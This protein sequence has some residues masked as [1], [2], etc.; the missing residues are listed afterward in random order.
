LT[1]IQCWIFFSIRGCLSESWTSHLLIC[2]IQSSWC[3]VPSQI[4]C[5]EGLEY[6]RVYLT[7][8]LFHH[9]WVFFFSKFVMLPQWGSSTRGISQIWLQV[10]EES[11]KT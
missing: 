1:T 11:R 6:L 7:T 4:C 3:I 2:E 9:A 10:R 8:S 5:S